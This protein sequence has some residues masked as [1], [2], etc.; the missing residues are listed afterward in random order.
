[1]PRPHVCEVISSIDVRSGGT[2][3]FISDLSTALPAPGWT[4]R[5][6][7]RID[8]SRKV[9]TIDPRVDVI[10]SMSADAPFADRILGGDVQRTLSSLHA[11]LPLNIVHSHGAWLP[12]GFRAGRWARARDVPYVISPHGTLERWALRHKRVKKVVAWWLYQRRDLQSAT[13]F[14]AC[15]D[16][17]AEGIRRLGFRQPIATI[18]NGTMVPRDRERRAE[19]SSADGRRLVLFLGRLS[20]IKG[21]PMLVE[22]WAKLAPTTWR[23]ILAG[24][25]DAGHSEQLRNL[26][27]H[28]RLEA[29]VELRGPVVGD[30]KSALFRSADVFVLPSYSENFGIVVA[31]ALSYEVPVITTTGCPWHELVTHRCGWWVPP[32]PEGLRDGLLQAIA[33]R[34]HDLR[35]MGHRGRMLVE[36]RY[37]WPAIAGQFRAFYLWLCGMGP[38]PPCVR[39]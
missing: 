34:D 7:T 19:P 23:L 35:S 31:E 6:L 16:Q 21:L 38:K 37:Q 22:A 26:I 2:S 29:T 3:S 15:S 17:E 11:G 36:S 33:T 27:H 10:A 18:P 28:H 1:M 8:P 39:D 9:V 32:T 5:L 13:A 4:F 25:D 12:F 24:P 20:P 14:H 30:E